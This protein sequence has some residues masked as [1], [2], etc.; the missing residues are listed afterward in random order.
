MNILFICTHNRCRS[1]V[2]EV[3]TKNICKEKYTVKSA[4]S[5]PA[6]A[7]HQHTLSNLKRHE[8]DTKGLISQ[9][10]NELGDFI[11]DICITVCDN[12]AKEACPTWLGHA[13][14]IHW[15]LIDPTIKK[16]NNKQTQVAF[17]LII[18]ILQ[19]RMT[20]ICRHDLNNLSDA[21]IRLL[22]NNAGE[23]N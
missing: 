15:S 14:K 21:D 6:G 16:I 22:F 17:D 12:A 1:I 10:W 23:L 2:A 11:P 3:I 19:K 4:G 18:N 13:T 7:V 8:Y 20:F 9:S 5:E